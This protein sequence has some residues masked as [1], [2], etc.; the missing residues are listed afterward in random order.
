MNTV[1]D[2]VIYERHGPMAGAALMLWGPSGLDVA[3]HIGA[4]HGIPVYH[5]FSSVTYKLVNYWYENYSALAFAVDT[6]WDEFLAFMPPAVEVISAEGLPQ[7][8]SVMA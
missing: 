2:A 7:F 3:S 6:A 5:P 1:E 4:V 8:L